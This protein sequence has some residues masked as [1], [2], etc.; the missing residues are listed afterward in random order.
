MGDEIAQ[1]IADPV[2]ENLQELA[3]QAAD[4]CP[5]EAIIVE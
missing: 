1:V 3:K 5:V 4:E 2:P